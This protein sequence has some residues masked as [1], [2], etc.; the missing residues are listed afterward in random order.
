MITQ[1]DKRTGTLWTE[2]SDMYTEQG[3]TKYSMINIIFRFNEQ[4]LKDK[5]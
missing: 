5:D 2:P 3:S 4:L 1:A